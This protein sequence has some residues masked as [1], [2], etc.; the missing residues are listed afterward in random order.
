[1]VKTNQQLSNQYAVQ[2]IFL[3]QQGPVYNHIQDTLPSCSIHSL[4]VEKWLGP[5]FCCK[6]GQIV[7]IRMK[8]KLNLWHR[9][10][11]VFTKFEIYIFKHVE[12]ACKILKNP[13]CAK[14]ILKIWFFKKT[15]WWE[16]YTAGH[17]CTKFE[18][19]ILIYETMI[20]KNEFE[21]LSAV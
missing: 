2:D 19:F 7:L 16:K 15:N 10:L 11:N 9:L 3:G 20:A 12:K 1:M 18:G 14:I 6:V 21:L 13:K 5:I 4:N 17:L 8:L